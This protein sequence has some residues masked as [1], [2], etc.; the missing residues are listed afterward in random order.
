MRNDK[1]GY[2]IS[3][4]IFFQQALFVYFK[5]GLSED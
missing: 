4:D 5:C 1:Y 3:T 2:E